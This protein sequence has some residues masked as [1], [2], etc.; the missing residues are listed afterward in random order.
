MCYWLA[1]RI[2]LP[3]NLG[4]N[5]NE[6]VTQSPVDKSGRL[7]LTELQMKATTFEPTTPNYTNNRIAY[8]EEK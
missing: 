1:H 2:R 3:D 6:L 8:A 4:L 5:I 7:G